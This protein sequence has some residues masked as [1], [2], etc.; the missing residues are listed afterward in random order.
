MP[1]LSSNDF[2]H[3]NIWYCLFFQA[4]LDYERHKTCGSELSIPLASN[5]EPMNVD[6]QVKFEF[7]ILHRLNSVQFGIRTCGAPLLSL[8]S[9][10][11]CLML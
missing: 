7:H 1:N 2:T 11:A 9:F 4:L 5:S 6:N 10:A 3:D 8:C